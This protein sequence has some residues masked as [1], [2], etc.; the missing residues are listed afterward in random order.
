V[1]S[2]TGVPVLVTGAGRGIG[3]RLSIGFASHGA[4]VG[5]MA[6][7]KAELDLCQLEIDHAGGSALRLRT[8]V[9]DYE[10]VNASLERMRVHFNAPVQVLICAAAVQGPIGAFVESAPKAWNDVLQT[11]LIGVMNSCRAVLPQM[12]ARRSG[13]IIVLACGGVSSGRPNFSVYALAKAG[14][15]RFVESVSEE[16]VEHNVQI[17]C[18]SPGESYTHMTDQILAAGDRAGWR[19]IEHAGKTRL[20]GGVA[21]DKQLNLALFLASELSNHVNGRII[22]ALDDWKKLKNGTISPDQYRLRRVQK[23]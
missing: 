5:L 1:H 22:G 14:L 13:K 6:R 7:S 10:Q 16:I 20:T 2:L 3:K 15:A 21:P 4:R 8:D 17:N 23:A 19:E 9:C 18:L 11:N 12:I